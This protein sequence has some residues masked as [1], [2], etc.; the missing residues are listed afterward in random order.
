MEQDIWNKR[1]K[2]N[3]TVYGSKPNEFFKQFIDSHKPGNLLLPADG[4]GRNA[5]YAAS[6]G[7]KVDAFDF[8]DEARIKALKSAKE[9]NLT[10]HYET[11][12]IE[13]FIPD[14]PYDAIGLIYVHLPE[15]IRK[16]FHEKVYQALAPGGYLIMEAFAKEQVK[17][18]SGGPKD[19]AL[20]YDAPTICGDFPFIHQLYCGQKVL[21]LDEG[22]FHSG[23][24]DVLQL[25]GQKV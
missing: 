11:K 18:Q 9:R 19:K 24:A 1:Y 5:L 16:P 20:L 25:L 14:K 10:I 21:H 4:E 2:E 12:R 6:R 8:S 15:A 17:N 13:D 23:Q 7:W 22:P 3:P